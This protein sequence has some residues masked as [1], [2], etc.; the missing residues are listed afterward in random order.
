MEYVIGVDLGTQ[1]TKTVIY[2]RNGKAAAEAFQKS[3]LIYGQKG[4]VEQDPME[5]LDSC[6]ATMRDAIQKAGISGKE[7]K[8]C[9]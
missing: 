3:N 8:P 5:L 7:E 4:C 1:G 2:D 6:V 9:H